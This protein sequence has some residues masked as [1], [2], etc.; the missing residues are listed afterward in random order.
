MTASEKHYTPREVADIWQVSTQ[1]VI[2]LF[3]DADGVLKISNPR[4]GSKRQKITLRI[5]S[6]VLERLHEQRSAGFASKVQSRRR[7]IK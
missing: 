7:G 5:P 1:T 2:R 6:S 4:F 3:Q